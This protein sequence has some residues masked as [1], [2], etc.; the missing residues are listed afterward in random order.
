M[1]AGYW[2]GQG[3]SPDLHAAWC[4]YSYHSLLQAISHLVTVHRYP[5]HL[6]IELTSCLELVLAHRRYRFQPNAPTFVEGSV[7]VFCNH[8]QT[9][10]DVLL[11]HFSS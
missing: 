8:H 1:T 10:Q 2:Q 11:W 9:S 4:K 3:Q 6:R 5:E 7:F